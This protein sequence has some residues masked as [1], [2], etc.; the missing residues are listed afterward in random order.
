MNYLAHLFLADPKPELLIGNLL[1]DFRTGV[2][3]DAYAPLIRMGIEQHLQIDAYTD[4]HPIVMRDRQRFSPP[5]RRFA[6]II[7]DV[8]YD[9]YLAKHWSSY[10]HISLNKFSQNVYQILQAYRSI[11]PEK[12]QRALPD[13]IEQDW[14]CSYADLEVIEYVLKRMANRFRRPTPIGASYA[15]ILLHYQEFEQGFLIFFPDLMQ[16]CDHIGINSRS[17]NLPSTSIN[18]PGKALPTES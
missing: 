7:L 5:Q 12:L 16:H 9:H 3:L 8:L 10:T 2:S 11:L 15:E 1:G 4:R 18:W 6:G 13:M 17:N 14:L